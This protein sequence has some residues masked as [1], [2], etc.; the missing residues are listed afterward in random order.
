M[1]KIIMVRKNWKFMLPFG[2]VILLI[3]AGLAYV[4]L[5]NGATQEVEEEV[6]V[7][8]RI[9]PFVN[10]AVFVE[11]YRI[12]NRGLMEQMLSYGTGWKDT[13]RFYYTITV[14][15]E[16]GSSQGNV[17]ETGV[18]TTWDTIGYESVMTFDVNE[19][20]ETSKI[21]IHI[22]E[23]QIEG[24]LGRRT[25]EIEQAVI[26]VVYDYR[27]GRWEGDD[28]FMDADGVGHYVGETYEVWFNVYQADYDND[29]IP[30]WTEVN[31]LSTDPTVDDASLDPDKDGIPTS[32]EWKW[33][34]DP[35]IW[36]DHQ[37]LDPD[38]D[39]IDNIEEYEM[40]KWF[41][42]PYQ[43]DIYIETDGMEE[44]GIIDLP[45]VFYKES[46][47][48][49]IERFAQH[50]M[51]VYI[52]DGWDD[53]PVNGGGE[54]LPFQQNLDDTLGKQVLAFYTHH[55]A[56]ERKGIFRY[57]VIGSI[58]GG[59]ITAVNYNKYDTM[60]IGNNIRSS[61]TRIAF[62]PREVRVMLAKAVLHELGHS[63]GLMP[64]TF[65][66]NDIY[67]RRISDRYPSMPDEEYNNY[68]TQYYS[69]MNFQYIYNKPF[70]YSDDTRTYLFD[71]SDGS[72]G[73]PY[74]QD[75]WK[76]VY[77]P[78][79]QIDV[80]SYEEPSDT[81]FEDFDIVNEYPGVIVDGWEFD[82]NLTHNHA[83]Q[84]EYLALIENTDVDIQVFVKTEEAEA[85]GDEYN[86]RVYAKPDVDPVYSIYSLVAEGYHSDN[87]TITLPQ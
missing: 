31:I 17:G 69:I 84:L 53:G 85:H 13:P 40:R 18:Y 65:P 57:V 22:I 21:S 55:F 87:G 50:G 49:I 73:A 80:T 75:D 24:L 37:H 39:G 54:M 34:Y 14:D 51:N 45:H 67:S 44:Q 72:N 26:S 38:I 79:F 74:D 36:N 32:W 33:G 29:G 9:S 52:D 3:F 61:F 58:D 28:G 43:Q 27:T 66:G 64:W 7:D 2:L 25:V 62:T 35:F 5:E 8:D 46:Q 23:E 11:V 68:L 42:D 76:H 70:F 59:F 16:S 30:Y 82:E 41:A 15:D 47:Q 71:Y 83:N 12:R 81:S 77:L 6:P 60:Y 56:D 4:L 10:Q 19:E 1:S 86:M 78:T 63:I 48:M 20:R